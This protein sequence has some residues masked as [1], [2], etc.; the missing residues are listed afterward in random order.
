MVYMYAA[1]G[2]CE[3]DLQAAVIHVY[4]AGGVCNLESVTIGT[5]VL[6][7]WCVCEVDLIKFKYL[8]TVQAMC[9]R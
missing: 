4:P 1:G 3:A 9:E 7:R 6:F 5:R 8:C 2:I